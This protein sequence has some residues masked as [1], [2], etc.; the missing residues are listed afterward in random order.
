[1]RQASSVRA[2][3]TGLCCLAVGAF[4]AFCRPHVAVAQ[5]SVFPTGVTV[6]DPRL[7]YNSYVLFDAPDNMSHLIDMDGHA[8]HTWS[9][10]GFPSEMIEPKLMGGRRGDIFVQLSRL[11]GLPLGLRREEAVGYSNR[12]FGIVNWNDK[13]VWQWGGKAPGGAAH[14]NHDQER[15]PNGDTLLIS[16]WYHHVKGFAL[17]KVLDDVIYEVKP[18]GAIVWRWVA[19]DHLGELG[20]TPHELAMIHATHTPEFLHLNAMQ[21]LGPNKWFARGDRR[22]A[23]GNIIISSRNANFVAIIDR[24][25]GGIAWEIG[26]HYVAAGPG[27]RIDRSGF[28]NDE[29]SGQHDAHMIPE[30]LPG[31]GDILIFD[32]QGEAGY[33]PVR[34]GVMVGS[35]VLEI[36]PQ[37]KRVVWSYSARSSG[38]PTWDFYSSFMGSAERLP[39]GNTLID[40]AMNGRFFQVTPKGKIVWEYVSPYFRRTYVWGVNRNVISNY[41][42]RVQAVPYDW[43]P[44]GT[45]HSQ[46]AVEAPVNSAFRDH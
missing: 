2:T 32:D 19:S 5:P 4:A 12:T 3:L 38:L 15:L 31:G 33:P 6:Y 41:A 42:Y 8:V 20:F 9:Y 28:T 7:A 10:V 35:R 11:K 27:Q 44:E 29:M 23:P 17:P 13:V 36:D 43:A 37:T 1:M 21:T 30:N 39:N 22:F 16:L 14:Q 26:P 34:L 24:K 45:P 25:T 40:E 46:V 18:D